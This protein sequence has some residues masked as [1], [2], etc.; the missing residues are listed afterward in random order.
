MSR[1]VQF[2]AGWCL[3]AGL[4]LVASS[5]ADEP[6]KQG[7][8]SLSELSQE[9]TALQTLRT[10]KLTRPQLEKLQKLADGTSV[11]GPV[12]QG[13]KASDDFRET[14]E[15]LHE[16]LLAGKDD[17]RIEEVLDNYE[18]LRDNEQP[19]LE[20][21]VEITELARERAPQLLRLLTA[22]QVAQFAAGWPE[23]ADPRDRVLQAL[24]KV[25]RIG[26]ESWPS[27]REELSE[28]IGRLVAGL[29]E[30]KARRVGDEVVQ[31]LIVA[32]SVTD[33]EFKKQR[34]ELEKKAREIVGDLGPLEVLRHVVEHALA[35]TLSNPRLPV[36]I[37]VR[38]K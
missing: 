30:D 36:A 12:P 15:E 22:G 11:K 5:R 3:I 25:R 9:V 24:D 28:E 29:D 35:E 20:D 26:A 1:C 4:S 17:D 21:D 16:L 8:L 27:Y 33:E 34:P 10:L 13:A 38:L 2:L 6:A 23:I 19:E 18:E 31:L 14:L 37:K 7:T 32:R